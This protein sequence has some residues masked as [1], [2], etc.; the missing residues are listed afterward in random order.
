MSPP[1]G[2][3][4]LGGTSSLIGPM[5]GSSI[6]TLLPE[7]LRQLAEPVGPML[8]NLDRAERFGWLGSADEWL[9]L[10]KLRNRMIH[11]YVR[12]PA[13]LAQALLAAH[14]VWRCSPR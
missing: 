10:R 5:L 13:E 6:L 8:D 12:N 7:L 4:V 3:T 11:E 2:V 9:A 14:G 1:P